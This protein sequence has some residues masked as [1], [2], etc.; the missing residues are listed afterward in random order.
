MKKGFQSPNKN[1]K[2]FFS[3]ETESVDYS[4]VLGRSR[5]LELPHLERDRDD[6][7]L[8]PQYRTGEEH[9]SVL[10][11][12]LRAKML[13]EQGQRCE[14]Q[15]FY[16]A[17]EEFYL[18]AFYTIQARYGYYDKNFSKLHRLLGEM[19]TKTYSIEFF[20]D[21][22]H[23]ALCLGK[24]YQTRDR[25]HIAKQFTH[26]GVIMN[27]LGCPDE[28]VSYLRRAYRLVKR[29]GLASGAIAADIV[30]LL[31]DVHERQ[32]RTGRAAACRKLSRRIRSAQ[33]AQE[34]SA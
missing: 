15:T 4:I 25:I 6:G 17:A 31:V 28:A 13:F 33:A 14:E 30:D 34:A 18:Q 7:V 2:H 24:S 26:L 10:T 16:A 20:R 19:Y 3:A 9:K 12:Y 22:A 32:G 27:R 1:S 29:E 8:E 5:A 21:Y 23:A 11:A